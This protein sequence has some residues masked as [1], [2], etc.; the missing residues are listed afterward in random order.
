MHYHHALIVDRVLTTFLSEELATNVEIY[1]TARNADQ[2]I[3]NFA[4]CVMRD[5]LS[6]KTVGV[7]NVHKDVLHA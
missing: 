1:R 4:V 2:P 6:T 5:T 7:L 3:P